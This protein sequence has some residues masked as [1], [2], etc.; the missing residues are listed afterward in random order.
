MT[1]Q[2][3]RLSAYLDGEPETGMLERILQNSELTKQWRNYHLIGDVMRNETPAQM[4]LDIAANVAAALAEEPTILAPKARRR[5]VLP[6]SVVQWGK[7]FGQ[8]AIAA[9]VAAIAVIG[10]QQYGQTEAHSVA[11]PVFQT[12]PLLGAPN[13]A[14]YQVPGL[15]Q[16]NELTA[17]QA[18]KEQQQRAHAFVHDHLLQQRLNGVVVNP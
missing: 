11:N 15:G 17:E 7:Q 13:L 2:K 16:R 18:A 12:Q 5:L 3:Q 10:V 14:S 6:A 8:Y 1:E 4:N 9:G